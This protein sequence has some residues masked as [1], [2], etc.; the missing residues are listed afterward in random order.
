MTNEIQELLTNTVSV[1]TH[2]TPQAVAYDFKQ[3]AG[4]IGMICTSVYAA[5]HLAFPKVQAFIDTRDGGALQWCF[6]RLFGKPISAEI[7]TAAGNPKSATV[8]PVAQ[9]PLV[10]TN[11]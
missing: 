5:F 2:V 9:P 7:Q 6:Y 11:Q 8:A 4:V 1:T 3:W 10:S